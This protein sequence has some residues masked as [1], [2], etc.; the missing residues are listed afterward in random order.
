MADQADVVRRFFDNS[1]QAA[2]ELLEVSTE[3]AGEIEAGGGAV[4]RLNR[5]IEEQIARREAEARAVGE[6][7]RS[8]EGLKIAVGELQ[9]LR[10]AERLTKERLQALD[11]QRAAV[12]GDF[13]RTEAQK[14]A[15]R[16]AILERET[17]LLAQIVGQLRERASL[18]G[19]GA[20][21]REQILARADSYDQQLGT[22]EG[23]L[24]GLGPDPASMTQQMSAAIAQLQNQFGTVQQQIA[25]GFSSTIQSAVDGVARG[26][27]GLLEGTMNWADALRHVGRSI[28]S[29]VISAISRMVA[30]WIAGRALI[31]A[32]EIF[33]SA[34]ET[35]AKAPNALLTSITSYG[36]AAVVGLAALTAALA[37]MGSFAGGGFTGTGGRDEPAGLVHRGEFVIPADRV[38]EYGIGF[39]EALRTGTVTPEAAVSSAGSEPDA[40]PITIVLVDSRNEARAWVESAEGRAR[41]VE[42]VRNQRTEIGIRS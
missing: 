37:A 11:R 40:K 15:A 23:R 32:K 33:F 35:A 14:F 20:E 31:A 16:R 9:R 2:R 22:A 19:I 21:E 17:A 38:N 4:E 24:Q 1:T 13:T 29:G 39:F 3:L 36:V 6:V 27:E 30:E 18:A 7:A 12:E 26:I 5:L 28:I 42:I 25:R 10:E 8:T 34:K 41:I